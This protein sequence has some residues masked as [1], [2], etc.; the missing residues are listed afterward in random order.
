MLDQF[1]PYHLLQFQ[2]LKHT[3]QNILKQNL[4]QKSKQSLGH[5]RPF[6]QMQICFLT[7]RKL[8]I[9]KYTAKLTFL[10]YNY[11]GKNQTPLQRNG[12]AAISKIV[13]VVHLL[14]SNCT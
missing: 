10:W 5:T 4:R 13:F 1:M 7:K 6:L 2:K 8:K 9:G 14:N 3:W 11:F 12:M